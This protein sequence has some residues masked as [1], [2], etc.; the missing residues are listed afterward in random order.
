MEINVTQPGLKAFANNLRKSLTEAGVTDSVIP[1]SLS[2][3]LVAKTLGFRNWDVLSGVASAAPA[4]EPSK[5]TSDL[6]TKASVIE[7]FAPVVLYISA[8]SQNSDKADVSW[9]KLTFTHEM[10]KRL[11]R[12]MYHMKELELGTVSLSDYF[13]TWDTEYSVPYSEV[14]V[15]EEGFTLRAELKH[16]SVALFSEEVPLDNLL[17]AVQG[18]GSDDCCRRI[19]DVVLYSECGA[20][21]FARDLYDEEVLNFTQDVV[22]SFPD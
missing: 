6:A 19:G 7:S 2:L 20:L 4:Q 14:A 3:E 9:V 13:P 22:D 11:K 15:A 16:G 12:V 17:D 1:Q 5:E 10:A 21:E 8:C 18:K